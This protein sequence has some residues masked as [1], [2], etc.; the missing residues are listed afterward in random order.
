MT[1]T[2]VP[3]EW[4]FGALGLLVAVIYGDLRWAVKRLDS[5]ARTR[6]IL[7]VR[8]CDKLNIHFTN[9]D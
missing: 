2:G 3:I 8:I 4:L 1:S 5:G 9:G 7:L 6:D